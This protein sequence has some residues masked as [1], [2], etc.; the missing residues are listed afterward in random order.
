MTGLER[1][2]DVACPLVPSLVPF[3]SLPLTLHC[4]PFTLCYKKPSSRPSYLLR[5]LTR[6]H[7]LF[8]AKQ[9]LVKDERE[10]DERYY[11]FA[12]I[13]DCFSRRRLQSDCYKLCLV[14]RV[15]VLFSLSPSCA[16][17]HSLV[18]LCFPSP[19]ALIF[20]FLCSSFHSL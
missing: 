18:T 3:S 7:V 15:F 17:V 16:L 20:A 4:R 13:C 11:I 2:N 14:V 5:L 9:A 19:F 12:F 10:L 6:L 8:R 1:E